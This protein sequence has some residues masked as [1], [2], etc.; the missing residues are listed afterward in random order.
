M[1]KTLLTV[2]LA[3]LVAGPA[4]GADLS[5]P[6]PVYKAPLAPVPVYSW[7]GFY[8]GVSGGYGF[9]S[10]RHTNVDNGINSGTDN[11]LNGGIVGLTYGYNWQTGPLVLG[12]EGDISWSGIKDSFHDNNNSGFCTRPDTCLTNLKWL[13]TDRARLGYAWDR[14][15][16]FATGGVAYG[17]VAATCCVGFPAQT[18]SRAGWTAGGGI[19][20]R[21]MPNWSAKLEYLYIDLGDKRNYS[22]NESVLLR[23]SLI[24]LGLNYRFGGLP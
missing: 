3:A 17:E 11:N 8:L 18:K 14:Y 15:L 21:L 16:V 13:G 24:R 12:L 20:A 22:T 6:A 1:K 9:G 4:L 5:R 7:T 23:T 19:E 2:A 10:T